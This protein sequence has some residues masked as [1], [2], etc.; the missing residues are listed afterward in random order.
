MPKELAE[1][2]VLTDH[3]F[4]P[5]PHP[6]VW[7]P[8]AAMPEGAREWG[9]LGY[10]EQADRWRS[11]LREIKKD[12]EKDKYVS[13]WLE[14]RQRAFAI[15]TGQIEGLYTLKFGIT[16]QL[17]VE[18]LK[19]VVAS[20]TVEDVED[21]TIKGLL[22]DQKTA[23]EMMSNTAFNGR[24]LTAHDLREWHQLL[25]RHQETVAGLTMDRKRVQ[26][27]FKNKGVWKVQP[28]N[29][30]R[31]DGV[32]HEYCPPEH[33]QSEMDRLFEMCADIHDGGYPPEVE[34]GWLHHRFVRIHPFQDGN[35]RVSRLLMAYVYVKQNLPPPVVSA[36]GREDYIRALEDANRGNLKRFTDYLGYLA[37]GT[38][39]G[40]A[41]IAESALEGRLT[42]PHA[43]GGRTVDN[44]YLPPLKEDG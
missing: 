13:N 32:M 40:A 5:D 31:P 18:G 34:A 22:A 2:L 16:E 1:H 17:M 25:T 33:V 21:R 20:H 41:E 19:G 37:L 3:L 44:E 38:V 24:P 28:N 35:G 10:Q 29:P 8:I 4:A 23:F 7:K 36:Q 43:C 11:L 26:V 39:T 12:P 27:P 15:E 30:R 14:E 42:R 6:E 9:F